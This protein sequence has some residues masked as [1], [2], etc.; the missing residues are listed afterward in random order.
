MNGEK[1]GRKILYNLLKEHTSFLFFVIMTLTII[2]TWSYIINIEFAPKILVTLFRRTYSYF[3]GT[4]ME[5]DNLKSILA[6]IVINVK[7]AENVGD[8]LF[9]VTLWPF[10]LITK[11]K[12]TFHDIGIKSP[13][14][15]GMNIIISIIGSIVIYLIGSRT[16][17]L[18]LGIGL[19]LDKIDISLFIISLLL[20]IVP[21]LLEEIIIRGYIQTEAMDI[22]GKWRG[23]IITSFIFSLG[24]I[25]IKL[26]ATIFMTKLFMTFIMGLFYGVL[27][28]K[29][30]NLISP[31]IGHILSNA[32]A[33]IL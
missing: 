6:N 28:S 30:K 4:P 10:I 22:F 12:K 24:H 16:G 19:Q 27:Y 31:I 33:G 5:L 21:V 9:F 26:T 8:F 29:N 17:L 2:W 25:E 18:L 14:G 1:E 7:L 32:F 3:S 20:A 11:R 23:V 15:E 13:S